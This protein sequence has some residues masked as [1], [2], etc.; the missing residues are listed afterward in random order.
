[1]APSR[2]AYLAALVT[3]ALTLTLAGNAAASCQSHT[4]LN[5]S[6]GTYTYCTTCCYG[7]YCTTTCH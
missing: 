6:T 1:M 2:F 3:L 5:L 4:I 7:G